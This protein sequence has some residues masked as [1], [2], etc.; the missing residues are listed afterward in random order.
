MSDKKMAHD[1]YQPQLL[2]KGYQPTSG[3]LTEP[4]GG[5]GQGRYG[6]QPVT[7]EAKPAQSQAKP[8]TNP[9]PKKP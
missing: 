8:A 6:Y 3:S 4:N 5:Q 9:P 2:K 7:N 1:G